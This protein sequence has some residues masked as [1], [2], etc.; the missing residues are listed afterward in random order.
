MINLK[1]KLEKNKHYINYSSIF[2]R[3]L[4]LKTELE[5]ANSFLIVVEN[6]KALESYLRISAYLDIKISSLSNLS[7]L[8]NLTYNNGGKYIVTKELFNIKLET[9]SQIEHNSL[10]SVKVGEEIQISD[11]TKKINELGYSF[12]DYENKGTFKIVGDILSFT[13]T[14]GD[15]TKISFW[16]NTIEDIIVDCGKKKEFY[17]GKNEVLDFNNISKKLSNEIKD[18]I[19][20]SGSLII[21]DS[22]DFYSSYDHVEESLNN[23][24]IFNSLSNNNSYIN[25]GINDLFLE[26][27]DDFK[28]ILE[29]SGIKKYIFT[30]NKNTI[31][32][33]LDLNN[34]DGVEVYETSLNNLKSFRTINACVI[35]D[36]NIS[37]IFVKKRI[38]R[39]LSKNLDLMMQIKPGDYIVHIDHGI[40]IFKEIIEKELTGIKKEY[41]TLEYKNNDKLFVPITEVSRVSKYV[42]VE[43]PKLTGLSTKEWQK[44]L[45]KVSEDV[46]IIARELLEVY[47]KRKLNKGY[48]FLSYPTKEVEFANSFD[49]TY[50]DDQLNII[51][52]IYDDMESENAM[53]RL[54]SG[55]VGF[56]K[57][58]IAFASIYKAVING[59]QAALISPLVVLAYEHYEKAI[60]RFS[61][62]PVN[63][64]VITRFEKPA[65]IKA[66]LERLKTGKIDVIVG[67]HRLLSE[68]IQ[69]KDL[70]LLIVDEEHKFGVKDK[71][72]IKKFKGD[73]DILSMSATPIPRSLNMALNGIKSI[74]M[75]T[76]PPVG[77][78]SIQTIVSSFDDKVIF[79]AGKREFDRAGQMFF[80][81][82]RVKT[83]EAMKHYLG[84]IFPGKKIAIVHGQLSG[85][86][87]EKRIIEFKRKQHDILL[88]TTVVENG[89]DF[90]NVNTIFINEAQ[91]FGISQIHQLR[92]RVGRSDRKGYCYLLFKKDKIKEDAAKRLKTIVDYS[93]LG[94]GF[95]LAI[96]D[97]EVRGG[98]D[99]LGIRQSGQGHDIGIKLFLEMLENRVEEL[100][101]MVPAP[102]VQELGYKGIGTQNITI[103]LNI[104]AYIDNSYFSS[105][106]DKINFYREIE[107]LESLDDLENIISDFKEINR[108]TPITTNNFF[109]LL[110]LK[111]KAYKF[112]IKS[113]RRVGINYQIDFDK[114]IT[115]EELKKFLILDKAVN[116]SVKSATRLRCKIKNFV[117]EEKFIEYVLQL[118]DLKLGKKK[119]KLKRKF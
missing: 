19:V 35:T 83:I 76:T 32:S 8:I 116:F 105:E 85:D 12:S 95:E 101:Q 58:E 108:D 54:L 77:R 27:I 36:D 102:K 88:A 62:F 38:K 1:I 49:Y 48:K 113:I 66:I 14:A 18:K 110:K 55:D 22:L 104:G 74:S 13:D 109:D 34:L 44:K 93:H 4:L 59:K 73:I 106:L 43:N 78:Q 61:G 112:K 21:L 117:N 70:G 67:T 31:K 40:G 16:G 9:F 20:E 87:L 25:L 98:G 114:S 99:I 89:I 90:S 46:E 71:E 64:G 56:G 84:N 57:T 50:T 3:L 65:V 97:L 11:I 96:K 33:F 29:E 63:I 103:D 2:S 81:H 115:L 53:D 118:F 82:N 15:T 107:S 60:E 24:I 23:Y 69:F 100:K 119:I 10:F 68:D 72:K 111:L 86:K 37:R 47:A 26:K 52:E 42:G 75:L 91:N 79:E 28:N 39:S 92:G 45:K 17:F 80:I 6:E 30:K 5:K 41:I 51:K 94:A 7:D